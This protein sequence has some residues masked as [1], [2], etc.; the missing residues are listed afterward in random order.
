M[1]K[2]GKGRSILLGTA[3]LGAIA[4]SGT[5]IYAGDV[6]VAV[7][8]T[9]TST[10]TETNTTP[11]HFGSVEISQGGDTITIDASGNTAITAATVINGSVVTGSPTSGLIT[12]ASPS[13]FSIQAAYPATVTVT[14][15]VTDATLQN[16]EPLSGGGTTNGAVVH[17]GGTP[18]T[19]Y[20]GG[21]LVIPAGATAGS[22]TGT[23]VVTLTYI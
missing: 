17:A 12:V 11:L 5:T 2:L 20:I 4:L 15:T 14:D 9:L 3:L 18:S 23:M 13:S 7:T 21:D 22:Y 6:N 8:A 1:V 10:L 16:I 19:I